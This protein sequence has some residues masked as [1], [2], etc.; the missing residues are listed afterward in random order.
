MRSQQKRGGEGIARTIEAHRREWGEMELVRLLTSSSAPALP[1]S[2]RG[3]QENGRGTAQGCSM[4]A[5]RR[6]L[7]VF[8][9]SR[10]E[11]PEGAVSAW[12]RGGATAP[13]QRPDVQGQQAQQAQARVTTC[14]LEWKRFSPATFF[15]LKEYIFVFFLFL[16]CFFWT[17]S[18]HWPLRL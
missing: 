15:F 17:H 1:P 9:R 10:R 7:P 5:A 2:T 6:S 12:W 16:Q 13:L 11:S 8:K 4:S 14:M 3:S 18:P